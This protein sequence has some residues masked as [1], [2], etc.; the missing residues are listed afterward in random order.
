M[1]CFALGKSNFNAIS[2]L[3]YRNV[4]VIGFTASTF[5]VKV[6]GLKAIKNLN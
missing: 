3:F 2:D 4:M 5:K 1:N 6:I